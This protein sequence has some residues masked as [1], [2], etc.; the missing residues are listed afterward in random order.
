MATRSHNLAIYTPWIQNGLIDKDRLL[1]LRRR[2]SFFAGQL[3]PPRGGAVGALLAALEPLFT[4]EPLKPTPCLS[5]LCPAEGGTKGP[6]AGH[7]RYCGG[8]CLV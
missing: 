6:T 4:A 5:G 2:R 1:A 8:Y 7:G 3:P